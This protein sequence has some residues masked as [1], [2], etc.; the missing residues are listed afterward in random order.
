[1]FTPHFLLS[2]WRS[3]EEARNEQNLTEKVDIFSMGHIFFRLICGHEPWN[4]LEVGVR[5]SKEEVN[6]KVKKGVLPH[7][8]KEIME[9][10]NMEE[11]AIRDA[12]LRCYTFEPSKRPSARVIAN[13]L[14]SALDE[15]SASS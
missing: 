7:I 2:Q 11:I 4:K 10:T 6:A 14:Q 8:P 1:L 3:P 12:M 9:T 13:A 15:L 5:P